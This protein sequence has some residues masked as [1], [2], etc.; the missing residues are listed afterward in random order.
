MSQLCVLT[1]LLCNTPDVLSHLA[2]HMCES[3]CESPLVTHRALSSP[4]AYLSRSARA[5]FAGQSRFFFAGL[6]SGL[7]CFP[8]ALLCFALLGAVCWLVFCLAQRSRTADAWGTSLKVL[9]QWLGVH[10]R[11]VSL[12]APHVTLQGG[13]CSCR[14]CG[15]RLP[16]D[17][18]DNP[19]DGFI[20]RADLT[21]EGFSAVLLLFEYVVV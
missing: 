13:R 16:M 19:T 21:G 7:L 10:R 4:A 3:P 11:P 14:A 8:C 9:A 1:A 5:P 18:F 15:P 2:S 20:L 17:M 12:G 6:S